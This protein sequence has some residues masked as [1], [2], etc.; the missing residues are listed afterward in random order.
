[1]PTSISQL[2]EM[3]KAVQV[4]DQQREAQRCSFVYGNTAIENS[5]ITEEMVSRN[6]AAM[7]SRS[8]E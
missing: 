6:A 7:P 8:H 2:I 5:R 3:A 4:T 1:M